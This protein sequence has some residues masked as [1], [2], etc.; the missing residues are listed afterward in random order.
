MVSLISGLPTS[1]LVILGIVLAVGAAILG[2][3]SNAVLGDRG[4]GL[5][6][7]GIVIT[8]AAVLGV[9]TQ[10]WFSGVG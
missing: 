5:V 2:A 6:V 3:I 9:A 4:C 7:N 10:F 1:S 8:L